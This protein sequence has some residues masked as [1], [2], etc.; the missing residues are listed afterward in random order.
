MDSWKIEKNNV[1]PIQR[2][3]YGTENISIVSFRFKQNCLS[4]FKFQIL[5]PLQYPLT[6]I[7]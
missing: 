6:F 2:E 5:S 4:N 3:F 7:L 1:L